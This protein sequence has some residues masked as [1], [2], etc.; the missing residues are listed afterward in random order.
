MM[1][2]HVY[3][4]LSVCA[5]LAVSS[6][7]PAQQEDIDKE[8]DEGTEKFSRTDDLM[9]KYSIS[10]DFLLKHP[11]TKYTA[12]L[13]RITWDGFVVR[14]HRPDVFIEMAEYMRGK[15][16]DADLARRIDLML[17][18][19]YAEAGDGVKLKAL[20]RTV[21]SGEN[22][23]FNNLYSIIG[24]AVNAG[25][26]QMVLDYCNQAK[27]FANA[28]EFQKEFPDIKETLEELEQRGRNRLGILFAY[29]GWAKENLGRRA[30]ALAD[31][32]AA[33]TLVAKSYMGYEYRLDLYWGRTLLNSGKTQE[34]IDKLAA[35]AL[36]GEYTQMQAALREAYDAKFSDPD[37][38]DLF[39][40]NLR[41]KIA[42][43]IDDF[44]LTNYQGEQLALS[45]L[46]GKVVMLAF[47]F[48]T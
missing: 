44:T 14:L 11:E 10:R 5:F 19:A 17:I 9:E 25:E 31:F 22:V 3:L 6:T 34:A 26:W 38:Y 47:W 27:R 42:Y 29:I 21:A 30:E 39:V 4:A 45:S 32:A 7:L 16:K 20:A 18:Q 8:F 46:K 48:P 36:L 12:K 35:G 23:T 24:A 2:F 33:D 37:G 1:K 41:K 43:P 28:E 40:E 15:I 13:L